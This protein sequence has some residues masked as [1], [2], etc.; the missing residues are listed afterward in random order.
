MYSQ[1]VLIHWQLATTWHI[2]NYQHMARKK[3]FLVTHISI[4]NCQI[5]GHMVKQFLSFAGSFQPLSN[6]QTRHSLDKSAQDPAN[7]SKGYSSLWPCVECCLWSPKDGT[8]QGLSISQGTLILRI[9]SPLVK[10]TLIT[11]IWQEWHW[12]RSPTLGTRTRF[13]Y[14]F[15]STTFSI[16]WVPNWWRLAVHYSWGLW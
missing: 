2:S 11:D 15:L 7:P 13:S 12:N 10:L 16:N 4:L 8:L 6:C 1:M 5:I 3:Y 14:S 9:H